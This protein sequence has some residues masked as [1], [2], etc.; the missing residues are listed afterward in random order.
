[1]P[2]K[3]KEGKRVVDREGSY[4]WIYEF[5]D[6]RDIKRFGYPELK[7]CAKM[8]ASYHKIIEKSGLNNNTSCSDFAKKEVLEEIRLFRKNIGN[9]PKDKK[10]KI[11]LKESEKLTKLFES[12]D[13]NDYSKL[14]KYPLHRDINPENTLWINKKLV[15]VIDFENVGE[16]KDT[17][18]KDI[19]GMLQ[20]SCRDRKNK[21]KLDLKLVKFFLKEYKKYHSL[22]KKEISFIPSLIIA[23]A[24]EDFSY[25]Y[26]MLL[27]DPERAKLS[28]LK[29]YSNVAQWHNEHS[30]E[31]LEKI[32][33]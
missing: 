20:Y 23:G 9:L 30:A 15:G 29:L 11:F 18:I 13:V 26:W 33:S 27:N 16:I 22:S 3:N 5:I 2:I 21:Y 32:S 17:L 19:A 6:G 28:R 31:M 1:M 10:G 25:S 4:F 14:K 24:I 7:E 12:L 8:M